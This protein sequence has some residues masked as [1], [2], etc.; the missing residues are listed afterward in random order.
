M[1]QHIIRNQIVPRETLEEAEKLIAE[2]R[3]RLE[4][5]LEKL[6]WWNKRVNLISR[7]VSRETVWKHIQHSLI[8]SYFQVFRSEKIIVDAGTGG[9]LPG[10]PLAI[11]H[12]KKHFV[13]NDLATKKCLALKQIVK[14]IDLKNV[15]IVDGSIGS[16]RYDEEFLLISK[17]A[18]KINDLLEMI[19]HLSWKKIL[20]YKGINFRDE[21]EEVSQTLDIQCFDLSSGDNFYN[22]K[23]ILM[24]TTL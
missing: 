23:A 17:H 4:S 22:G 21:L 11:T 10:I 3:S 15:G 24:I 16:L 18:F 14:Q 6:L 20:L 7:N 2:N 13:L 19:G 5:Y 12:P 9:G 1:K 8:I